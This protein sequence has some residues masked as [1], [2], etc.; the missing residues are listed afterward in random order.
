MLSDEEIAS[1]G[2]GDSSVRELFLN[3]SPPRRLS[4][5]R[6]GAREA[7]TREKFQ[8]DR[9][10]ASPQYSHLRLKVNAWSFR[11]GDPYSK[12]VLL[13]LDRVECRSLI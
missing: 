11:C 5:F 4:S 10:T 13:R 7:R 12:L 1:G 2:S 8:P 6:V 9:E 3:S